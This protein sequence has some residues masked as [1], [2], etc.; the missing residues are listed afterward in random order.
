MIRV[1]LVVF[2]LIVGLTCTEIFLRVRPPI[3]AEDVLPFPLREDDLERIIEGD[4]YIRFD[5]Y[6]GW[7]AT[8]SSARRD[9]K[10]TYQTNSVGMPRVA[11]LLG[12]EMT[13]ISAA[14]TPSSRLSN[15][16]DQSTG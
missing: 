15:V 4:A 6:L 9:G 2:G 1:A 10:I 13:T 7:A 11:L 16:P 12:I 8:E 5:P 3:P 14:R